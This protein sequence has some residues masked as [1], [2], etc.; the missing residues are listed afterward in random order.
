V[1]AEHHAEVE[2]L[3]RDFDARHEALE[4]RDHV[5]LALLLAHLAQ[6]VVLVEH[7]GERLHRLDD[8]ARGFHL[9]DHL[10]RAL[11][12]APEVGLGLELLDLLQSPLV[13]SEVKD[14]P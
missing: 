7:V 1:P 10:L 3:D 11:R 13:G 14:S 2:V 12:V 4:I 6:E 8:A 9:G 5:L